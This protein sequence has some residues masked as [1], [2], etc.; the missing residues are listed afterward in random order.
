MEDQADN[1]SLGALNVE[2]NRFKVWTKLNVALPP[3]NYFVVKSE[4][5]PRGGPRF[6]FDVGKKGNEV[7]KKNS[8]VRM[9][10]IEDLPSSM[11]VRILYGDNDWL[12]KPQIHDLV[13][14]F[15][16]FSILS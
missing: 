4:R 13:S 12:Y 5:A 3:L 16:L 14:N 8:A 1:P 11:N 9:R 15:M 7:W 10:S 6:K 2:F